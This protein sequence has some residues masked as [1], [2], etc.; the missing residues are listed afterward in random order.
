MI[1]STFLS[2][3]KLSMFYKGFKIPYVSNP[4]YL[5]IC[6]L[7]RISPRI[8]RDRFRTNARAWPRNLHQCVRACLPCGHILAAPP[9]C[10]Y[11][12]NELIKPPSNYLSYAERHTRRGQTIAVP[13][14]SS[15]AFFP[16]SDT[17][18]RAGSFLSSRSSFISFPCVSLFRARAC[19]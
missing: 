19:R 2:S 7:S 12:L 6:P 16:P 13:G 11:Y 17:F 5:E 4:K 14:S 9:T 3:Q 8:F 15:R 18:P 1:V 10:S